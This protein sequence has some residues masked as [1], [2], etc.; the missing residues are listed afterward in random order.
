MTAQLAGAVYGATAIPTAWRD[1]VQQWDRHGTIALRARKLFRREWVGMAALADRP[2]AHCGAPTVAAEAACACTH[3]PRVRYCRDVCRAAA[4]ESH[5]R[6]CASLHP[7][8][9][10]Q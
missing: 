1:A 5:T 4:G 9:G 7:V 10:E 6:F 2:C 8:A 3:C